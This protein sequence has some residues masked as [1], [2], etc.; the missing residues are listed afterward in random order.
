MPIPHQL[1]QAIMIVDKSQLATNH[2]QQV[3][4]SPVLLEDPVTQY[5]RPNSGPE[6]QQLT[7]VLK[8]GKPE[9]NPIRTKL[10]R[11]SR[12]RRGERQARNQSRDGQ[13][14]TP[15]GPELRRRRIIDGPVRFRHL[16]A[17]FPAFKSTTDT[18]HP[19]A[20]RQS[21]LGRRT[22]QRSSSPT[23]STLRPHQAA[24]PTPLPENP[25]RQ[26]SNNSCHLPDDGNKLVTCD[27]LW[28]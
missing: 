1:Q 12:E 19:N 24:T 26:A 16:A 5:N 4:A 17:A 2:H 13:Q 27:G 10:G 18:T 14:A 22:V 20:T 25:P 6:R 9:R 3:T 23:G 11:E 15:G 8:G 28:R 21:I 7:T